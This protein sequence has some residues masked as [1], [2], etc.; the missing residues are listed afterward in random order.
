M[1][2]LSTLYL[3]AKLRID[4]NTQDIV[5][6]GCYFCSDRHPTQDLREIHAVVMEYAATD[7][8]EARKAM[9]ESLKATG[10]YG[11]K[12]HQKVYESL[13]PEPMKFYSDMEVVLPKKV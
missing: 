1:N 4:P 12:I 2:N 3:F 11:S 8:E 13:V 9:L 5:Y 6:T 7:L 10:W